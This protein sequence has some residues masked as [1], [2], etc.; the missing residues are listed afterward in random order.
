M[1]GIIGEYLGMLYVQSKQRPTYIVREA[2][3]E[4]SGH[5]TGA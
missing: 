1:L 4:L 2:S 5:I 3:E